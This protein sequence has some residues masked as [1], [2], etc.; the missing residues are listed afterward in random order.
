MTIGNNLGGDL[1]CREL[2]RDTWKDNSIEF[3]PLD[4]PDEGGKSGWSVS[5]SRNGRRVAYGAPF[6]DHGG[7]VDAGS[8]RVM[9][10]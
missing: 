1:P 8:V 3:Q 7:M 6:S 10:K 5:Y 4:D 9:E 2:K